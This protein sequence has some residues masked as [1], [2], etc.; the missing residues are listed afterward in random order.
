MSR[1][2]SPDGEWTGPVRFRGARRA[3][4]LESLAPRLSDPATEAAA[5]RDLEELAR[6]YL[7]LLGAGVNNRE[8]P[9]HRRRIVK[10]LDALIEGANR[11]R[12][13]LAGLSDA[14]REELWES[15]A[16]DT[17]HRMDA[18]CDF[19][20][21][22]AARLRED[23]ELRCPRKGRPPNHAALMITQDLAEV[24]RRYTEQPLPRGNADR[25][26]LWGRFVAAWFA[27]V[28]PDVNAAHLARRAVERIHAR[29]AAERRPVSEENPPK[30]G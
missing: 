24:W 21:L 29:E 13:A 22:R 17:L 15:M 19:L 2:N 27:A 28:D 25:R 12:A 11:L 1:D 8:T 23:V 26:T 18:S 30:K 6:H 7:S 20:S 5:L 16:P 10:E 14:T 9:P 3:A 4:I